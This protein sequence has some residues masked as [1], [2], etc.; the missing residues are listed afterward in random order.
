[1]AG[2]TGTRESRLC[3][4]LVDSLYADALLLADEA[5]AWFDRARGD[6][7]MMAHEALFAIAE[8]GPAA[9]DDDDGGLLHWAGRNDPS[10]RIALSCESLRLTTRLMHVIAWLLMQRAIA[11]GEVSADIALVDAHRLG[12]SPD[13]DPAT[14]ATL[15]IAAQ[16]LVEASLRLHERVATLEAG[17][18]GEQ[19]P[20]VPEVHSMFDRLARAL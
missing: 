8:N 14:R 17:I 7:Q 19:V 5:R 12:P 13:S 20:H 18:L 1:M 3:Q 6:G 16:R 2:L 10:L 15:P 4:S 9:G 11:A